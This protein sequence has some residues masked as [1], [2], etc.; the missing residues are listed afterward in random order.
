MLSLPFEE[1]MDI[2]DKIDAL[3]S[4]FQT[5]FNSG[6]IA[7]STQKFSD[8]EI[9]HLLSPVGFKGGPAKTYI[10]SFVVKEA[11]DPEI[12]QVKKGETE[13]PSQNEGCVIREELEPKGES[14]NRLSG[15]NINDEEEELRN[16]KRELELYISPKERIYTGIFKDDEIDFDDFNPD[17]S[18]STKEQ[19]FFEDKLKEER[20]EE[21]RLMGPIATGKIEDVRA[22]DLFDITCDR[23]SIK[24]AQREFFKSLECMLELA[25]I[26]MELK[27]ENS[28]IKT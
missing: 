20:D 4:Q 13:S 3:M 7:L 28:L 26:H 25:N 16:F 8:S 23:P 19:P 2:L 9:M 24:F 14:I 27:R 17:L 10:H 21:I 11:E 5:H 15:S 6:S 22:M 18:V 12:N 1:R